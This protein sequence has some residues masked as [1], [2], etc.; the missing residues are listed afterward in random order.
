MSKVRVDRTLKEKQNQNELLLLIYNNY[1][2]LFYL[3]IVNIVFLASY[4]NTREQAFLCSLYK[5]LP[6]ENLTN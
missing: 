3:Y 1:T 4:D 6:S 5:N 2:Y